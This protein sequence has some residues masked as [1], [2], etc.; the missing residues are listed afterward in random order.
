MITQEHVRELL[1]AEDEDARLVLVDGTAVVLSGADGT[2]SGALEVLSRR[3]LAALLG[4]EEPSE[5]KLRQVASAL[6][7]TAANRGA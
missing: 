6:E 7:T 5:E 4:T 3:D 2:R 1:A